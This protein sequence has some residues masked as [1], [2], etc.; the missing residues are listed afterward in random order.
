[1]G[2]FISSA[3]SHAV[4]LGSPYYMRVVLAPQQRPSGEICA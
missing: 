3:P 1:M 4:P 2:L